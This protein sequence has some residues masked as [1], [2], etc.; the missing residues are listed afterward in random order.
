MSDSRK[1]NVWRKAFALALTTHELAQQARGA[2]HLSLRSQLI[3]AST[4][5]PS[6]IA[7]GREQK[8]E[9]AFASFLRHAPASASIKKLAAGASWLEL[10]ALAGRLQQPACIVV[11]F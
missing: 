8:T 1:L 2:A 5:I 6:N 4:S 3:R 7:E 9:R 11:F 10:L